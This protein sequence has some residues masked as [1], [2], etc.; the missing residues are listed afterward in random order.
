MKNIRRKHCGCPVTRTDVQGPVKQRQKHTK[1][2]PQ[3]LILLST[4]L[5][6]FRLHSDM[7]SQKH[8]SHTPRLGH[9]VA[10]AGPCGIADSDI[11]KEVIKEQS[12]ENKEL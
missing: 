2:T 9:L 5:G 12:I 7:Q 10:K 4:S 1:A 3:W 6:E 8:N 11:G